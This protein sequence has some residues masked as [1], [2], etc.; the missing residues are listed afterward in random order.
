MFEPF[1]VEGV[2]FLPE[3]PDHRVPGVLTFSADSR[4][5]RELTGE[6]RFHF[7]A[8][9]CANLSDSRASRELTGEHP[10]FTP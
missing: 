10:V 8:A 5:S 4:A 9:E 7:F 1:T 2:W 6:H 3:A